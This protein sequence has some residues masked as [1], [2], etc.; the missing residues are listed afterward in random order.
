MVELKIQKIWTGMKRGAK[1]KTEYYG[2]AQ[3]A[4]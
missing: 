4:V 2:H 1:S 3:L